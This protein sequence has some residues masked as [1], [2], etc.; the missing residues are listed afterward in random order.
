M[1]PTSAHAG[2]QLALPVTLADYATFDNFW[3][4]GNEEIVTALRAKPPAPS[5]WL[6]GPAHVGKSHLLQANCQRGREC[7]YL[8]GVILLEMPAAALDGLERYAQVCV[9]DVDRLL[10]DR[11]REEALFHLY[12]RL[13]DHGRSLVLAAS[14]PPTAYEFL[15]PDLASRLRAAMTLAV[16]PLDD[17]GRLAALKLR[18]RSRGFEL[19]SVTGRYLLNHQRRDMR[20][21]CAILDTLDIASLA[22]QRRLTV[23]FV[24]TIL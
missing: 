9:D 1:T 7:V 22:A 14:R 19:P 24:K 3:P 4:A 2:G 5:L 18:A 10:G 20:S 11:A 23:P 8:T 12:N 15:L 16:E 6:H 17:D 21:L 13:I